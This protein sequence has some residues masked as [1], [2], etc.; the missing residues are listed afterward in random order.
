MDEANISKS[1]QDRVFGEYFLA[2]GEFNTAYTGVE[3]H[4]TCCI[5]NTLSRQMRDDKN[6]W[7]I[8]AI[9]GSMRMAAAKDTIKRILRVQSA[10]PSRRALVDKVFA[11]LG[12][13]D[14]FRNRLAYNATLLRGTDERHMLIHFDYASAKE[15]E[16]SQS[17]GFGPIVL[18]AASIDMHAIKAMTDDLM[19]MHHGTIPDGEVALP[20]WQ[21][22]P[23]VLVRHRPKSGDNQKQPKREPR[24]SPQ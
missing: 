2:L 22:K 13:L 17:I 12:E 6:E 24:P 5:K 20:A 7:L 21:Y 4:F 11:H 10:P 19:S 18:R 9:V 16:K 8:N 14:W 23:S 3:H 1:V 15:A